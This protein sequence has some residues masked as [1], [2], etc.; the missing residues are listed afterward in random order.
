MQQ[1]N[2]I[3]QQ[4]A[5]S[6]EEFSSNS[7]ELIQQAERLK[8]LIKRFQVDSISMNDKPK[9][10]KT[11]NEE[12]SSKQNH[13]EDNKNGISIDMNIDTDDDSFEQY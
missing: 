4:N 10:M 7:E 6:A 9:E 12:N 11:V 13:L 8:K 3:T 2:T 1:L 5:A